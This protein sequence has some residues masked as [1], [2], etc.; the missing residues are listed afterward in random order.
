[1]IEYMIEIYRNKSPISYT[2]DGEDYLSLLSRNEEITT[3]EKVYF[4]SF[5]I[6]RIQDLAINEYKNKKLEEIEKNKEIQKEQIKR[7][8]TIIFKSENRERRP[9]RKK[10]FKKN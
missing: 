8:Q 5:L 9:F 7:L 3:V 4:K 1:M 2:I 6:K 10:K